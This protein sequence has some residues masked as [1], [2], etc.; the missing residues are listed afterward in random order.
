MGEVIRMISVIIPVYNGQEYIKNITE[1]FS[2]QSY[3]DF[4]LIF[5][6]DGSK[7]KSLSNL[8][9]WQDHSE[10][11]IIIVNQNNKGV[12]AARNAGINAARGE[13]LCFCDVDD[14]VAE[15]YLSDMLSVLTEKNVQMVFCKY[16]LVNSLLD[17]DKNDTG[18]ILLV[19]G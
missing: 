19:I 16:K 18:K 2:R 3:R 13:F 14:F 11:Q 17:R 6:N 7:D 4:E 9:Y 12:S 1:S 10:M 5:V 15:T 8:Q